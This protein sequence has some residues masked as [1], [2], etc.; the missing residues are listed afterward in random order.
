[1]CR[2]KKGVSETQNYK[3]TFTNRILTSYF[4]DEEHIRTGTT[5]LNASFCYLPSAN[6]DNDKK[7]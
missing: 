5:T 7:I 4:E 1:M 3:L 6:P 2:K